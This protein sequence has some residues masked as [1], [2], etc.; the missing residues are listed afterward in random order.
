MPFRYDP[1]PLLP[2]TR[3]RGEETLGF[4]GE[5]NQGTVEMMFRMADRH[6]IRADFFTMSRSGDVLLD[7]LVQFGDDTY[8]VNDRVESS[9]DLR[10][11]GPHLRLFGAATRDRSRSVWGLECI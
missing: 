11:L 5:L 1:S 10:M 9:M 2:G 7:Q 6:R 8:R 3:F 4:D